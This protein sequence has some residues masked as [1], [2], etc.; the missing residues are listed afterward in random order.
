MPFPVIHN[1]S[2]EKN[3]LAAQTL[4]SRLWRHLWMPVEQW[5]LVCLQAWHPMLVRQRL[6]VLAG[7]KDQNQSGG[8]Y[9]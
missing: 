9:P 7:L 6:A 2:P 1:R 5:R 3:L 4:L 8:A